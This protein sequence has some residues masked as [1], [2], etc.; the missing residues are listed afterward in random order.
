[1]GYKGKGMRVNRTEL[2]GL[3]GV[4]PTTID[5]WVRRG[6]P[7]LERPA[8]PGLPSV[9]NTA[10]VLAWHWADV[11]AQEGKK[12]F[13]GED[14]LRQRKLAAE[15]GR[16]ELEHARAM[17]EVAPVEQLQQAWAIA[18]GRVR[19]E[20]EGLAAELAPRLVGLSDESEVKEL[21]RREIDATLE[22]IA[23]MDLLTEEDLEPEPAAEAEAR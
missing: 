23:T 18:T 11:A 7:I 19:R 21:M 2:A 3:L 10:D 1:M 6:C 9:F 16:A 12:T 8:G 14:E 17:S 4:S 22:R 15:A 20:I 13:P 5:A